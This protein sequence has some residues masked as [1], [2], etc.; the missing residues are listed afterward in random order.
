M[1]CQRGVLADQLNEKGPVCCCLMYGCQDTLSCQHAKLLRALPSSCASQC[2]P[3]RAT[4][5]AEELATLRC[6]LEDVETLSGHWDRTPEGWRKSVR[7]GCEALR[8]S[9]ISDGA[10]QPGTPQQ[11]L[12]GASSYI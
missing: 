6:K 10:Y 4:G 11:F 8:Q 5:K 7:A 3:C 1:A 2:I 12:V 9:I